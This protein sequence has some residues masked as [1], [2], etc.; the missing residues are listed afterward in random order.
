[1]SGEIGKPREYEVMSANKGNKEIVSR[2]RVQSVVSKDFFF[3]FRASLTISGSSQA[4][5]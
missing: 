5:G 2:R 3:F 1:M 4:R